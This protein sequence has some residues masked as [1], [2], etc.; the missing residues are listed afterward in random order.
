MLR[1]LVLLFLCS[2][3]GYA[4][5][6][7]AQYMYLDTNGDGVHT[8]ADVLQANGTPS[9][10]DVWLRTNANRDGSPA[11]CNSGPEP[12]TINSY[13]VN[14]VA[15]GGTVTYS[16]FI[17]RQPQWGI[18]FAPELNPDGVHYRNGYGG[19]P[20]DPP[21]LYQLATLTITGQTGTPAIRIV[22]LIPGSLDHTS[23]GTQCV[24]HEF[25]NTYKLAGPAG[26]SDWTD[27]DGTEGGPGTT[28]T[29]PVLSPIGTKS[30]EVGVPLTFTATAT[31][32][33]L[34]PQTLTFSLGPFTDVPATI[35]PSS[36]IFSWTP[37]AAGQF[38][39]TILVADN[40]TPPLSDFETVQLMIS[41]APQAPVLNPIADLTAN[42]GALVT[43]VA[44]ASHPAPSSLSWTLGPG[45][46]A[47]AS[48]GS[49]NGLF[50]WVIAEGQGPG[51]YP[52]TVN[53]VSSADG[54]SDSETF[55][56]TVDE[57]NALPQFTGGVG[58]MTVTEG[59]TATQQLTAFD[60]DIPAQALFFSKTFG[61]PFVLV[62]GSGLITVS[63]GVTDSGTYTLRVRVSDGLLF[64]ENSLDITVL[65]I[66]PVAD[67]GGPYEGIVG[68]PVHFDATGSSDA[69]GNP[70]AFLWNFGDGALGSGSTPAHT[71]QGAAVYNVT[72][73]V[74]S[75]GVSDTDVTT[76]TIAPDLELLAFTTGGNKAVRLGSGKQQMCVQLE[77]V[78][79]A[80]E[81]ADLAPGSIRMA[82]GGGSIGIITGKTVLG[83]DKNQNGVD[84]ITACFSK[85]DLRTLFADLPNG[86][87]TVHVMIEA[88]HVSGAMAQGP[89]A[90]RVF[91]SGGRS[92]LT[93]A[94]NPLNPS[95]TATFVTSRAGSLRVGLY[96]LHG[97]LVRTLLDESNAAAGYHDVTIDGHDANG[98][99]LASGIYYVKVQSSVDGEVTKAITILK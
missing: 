23:F 22:D 41:T 46:P 25:D 36:G 58:D 39:A 14:F 79:G 82:Y 20:G 74:T 28:N 9:T 65:G 85:D 31:D 1:R 68:V 40:G 70:L 52:I 10:V 97:R 80:F 33:D 2:V 87:Q 15:V 51:V 63:P 59:E 43:F 29:P 72:L 66:P 44:T 38:F 47:G 62:S 45:A 99:R 86:E 3:M 32:A 13:V 76:A 61:P 54:W 8:T 49:A 12:L 64:S 92:S 7:T 19:F 57:V 98:G 69:E 48:I 67:A 4:P 91:Q 93:I 75:N 73:T 6:V 11:I 50:Q 90:L 78:G 35:D 83:S 60:A 71:Y 21:G 56:V 42:E 81:A 18:N 55:V 37:S 77:P 84:E 16:G 34:P 30:G 26:G 89:L 17:N 24:G 53:V 27:A 96:D 94:P 88:I 95:A 5:A